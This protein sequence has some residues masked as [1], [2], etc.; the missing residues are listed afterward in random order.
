MSKYLKQNKK[1]KIGKIYRKQKA[2]SNLL[3]YPIKG[4]QSLFDAKF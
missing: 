2:F 4:R 1:L 3:F